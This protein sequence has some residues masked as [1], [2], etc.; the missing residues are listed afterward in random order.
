MASDLNE[1]ATALLNDPSDP[2][3]GI[4]GMPPNMGEFVVPHVATFLGVVGAASKVYSR[5]SDEALRASADN[6]RF[7]L[8]DCRI[9]ECIEQ[10]MR[11]VALL[12]W[13]VEPDDP[14]DPMQVA[15]QNASVRSSDHSTSPS[16]SVK[17]R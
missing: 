14:T 9:T 12:D 16:R 17:R 1:P 3:R 8:N 7:M 15:L 11:S 13:H 2:S 6:A 4:K 10:R 5:F